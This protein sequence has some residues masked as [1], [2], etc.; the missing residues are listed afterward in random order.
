MQNK[1]GIQ[2]VGNKLFKTGKDFKYLEK[3]LTNQ[4][5]IHEEIKRRLKSRNASYY[6]VQNILSS[7]LLSKSVKTDIQNYNLAC[8][9]V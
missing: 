5:S 2:H 6:S 4:N 7:S 9:F 1:I 8:C 3:T